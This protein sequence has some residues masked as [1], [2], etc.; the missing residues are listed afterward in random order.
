MFGRWSK[1][2]ARLSSD[3]RELLS[4]GAAWLQPFG[5]DNDFVGLGVFFGTPSD[6]QK[7]NERGAELSY[8]LRFT[9]AFSLMPDLQY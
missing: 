6:S 4:L 3:Y 8:K 7:G 5:Y 2:F 9:Q 1:S